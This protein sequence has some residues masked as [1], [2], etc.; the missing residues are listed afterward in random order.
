MCFVEVSRGKIVIT[1]ACFERELTIKVAII[2]S[3]EHDTSFSRDACKL[4]TRVCS[5]CERALRFWF[6]VITEPR[7][8]KAT[9]TNCS[10]LGQQLDMPDTV[11]RLAHIAKIGLRKTGLFPAQFARYLLRRPVNPRS[12]DF[13]DMQTVRSEALQL[14]ES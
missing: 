13:V 2:G 6:S 9:N 1:C 8:Y 4:C 11:E 12:C 10:W 5:S 3:C 14:P 7:Q